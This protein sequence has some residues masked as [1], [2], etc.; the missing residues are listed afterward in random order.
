MEKLSLKNLEQQKLDDA[1]LKNISGGSFRCSDYYCTY[2]NPHA[3]C[4]W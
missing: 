4:C 2:I 1:K 3:S